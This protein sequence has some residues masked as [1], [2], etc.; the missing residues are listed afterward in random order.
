MTTNQP[1]DPSTIPASQAGEYERWK[2]SVLDFMKSDAVAV[3][4]LGESNAKKTSNGL[5][6]AVRN[7]KI[8]HEVRVLRRGNRSFLMK[9]GDPRE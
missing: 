5:R 2:R 4:V 6:G 7:L 8:E 1:I 3:E 9:A